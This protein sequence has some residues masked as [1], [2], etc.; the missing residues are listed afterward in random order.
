MTVRRRAQRIIV[1][2]AALSPLLGGSAALPAWAGRAAD[3]ALYSAAETPQLWAKRAAASYDALQ[4]YLYLGSAGHDL[5]RETTPTPPGHNPYSYVWEFRE[6]GQAT[7]DLQNIPGNQS[8]FR[9]DVASRFA[10]LQQY[11]ST[12]PARPGYNSYVPPPLGKGGDLY[13][14]DNAEVGLSL[15]SA[16]H[17]TGDRNLIGRARTA[18]AA[19][20]RG[21]DTDPSDTCPGGERWIENS[22]NK[23][24]VANS[25]GL[26]ALLSVELYQTTGQR[27]YLHWAERAYQWNRTCLMQSA[28]LYRNG[29]GDDGTVDPTL[30]SYNSGAMIGTAVQL[31]HATGDQRFLDNAISDADGAL[32]YWSQ[33]DRLYEQPVI[34]NAYFFQDLL[35]LDSV[36]HD[37]R[38]L[39]LLQ[40]YAER[41][42]ADNLDPATGLFQFNA[43]HGGAPDPALPVQTLTQSA[44]VQL[45]SLLAWQPAGYAR[46]S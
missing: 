13:Y 3:P 14:D 27:T 2:L 26:A 1:V 25:T 45:F 36:H 43:D 16:Y 32:A 41:L 4:Q 24:R 21:W 40:A 15:V 33:G 23:G 12:N 28:G 5:Y 22:G 17:A 8:T 9:P 35:L 10:A 38:C 30:W 42:W 19:D 18:F 39:A 46:I 11:V 31:Y 20:A 6:A 7:L 34:F 44:V 29:R 37:P